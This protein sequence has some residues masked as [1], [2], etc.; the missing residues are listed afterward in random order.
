MP[1]AGGKLVLVA[2][3]LSTTAAAG[4][5]RV[6]G[7]MTGSDHHARDP[8]RDPDE[9]RLAPL[10]RGHNTSDHSLHPDH[11]R[12]AVDDNGDPVTLSASI[13]S[14]GSST[15]DCTAESNVGTC[16]STQM[17]TEHVDTQIPS[18]FV[19]RGRDGRGRRA[20]GARRRSGRQR[21]RRAEADG[22][23]LRQTLCPTRRP[24]RFWCVWVFH[25]TATDQTARLLS[26]MDGHVV[27]RWRPATGAAPNRR[28]AQ[29]VV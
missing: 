27:V 10:I 5:D 26:Q 29:A 9:Q 23:R 18:T 11:L 4:A 13:W 24:P 15:V 16:S 22:H 14:E 7:V 19:Q 20:S 25:R 6:V 1:A 28:Q 12:L 8:P 17:F 3:V 21:Q 2:A